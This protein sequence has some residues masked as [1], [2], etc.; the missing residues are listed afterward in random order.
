M[1]PTHRTKEIPLRDK[2]ILNKAAPHSEYLFNSFP[3]AN[4]G[5]VS[6]PNNNGNK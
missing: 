4:S 2:K 1:V 5:H 6:E 3:I